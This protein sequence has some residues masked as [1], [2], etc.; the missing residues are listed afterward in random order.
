MLPI[1]DLSE[2]IG[3][4]R[5]NRG[6]Y[7]TSTHEH[8]QKGKYPGRVD[9]R[10]SRGSFVWNNAVDPL[11]SFWS[12]YLS[13]HEALILISFVERTV[14]GRGSFPKFKKKTTSLFLVFTLIFPAPKLGRS[15]GPI[16]RWLTTWGS[17]QLR[18]RETPSSHIKNEVV[19][20]LNW[21]LRA[22]QHCAPFW[23]ET[24]HFN[25][26][27]FPNLWISILPE[28][29]GWESVV[30][31]TR[32]RSQ[33]SL[34]IFFVS[35]Q[36]MELWQELVDDL[37][38]DNIQPVEEDVEFLQDTLKLNLGKARDA[39]KY[40]VRMLLL[41]G[42]PHSR[43]IKLFALDITSH[44]GAGVRPFNWPYLPVRISI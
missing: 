11:F 4:F 8:T 31:T 5:V 43:G 39:K 32:F 26:L 17:A 10:K 7:I 36:T 15:S 29:T 19:F 23:L 25:T 14:K 20:V 33:P 37:D 38:E 22:P 18:S 27:C 41:K 12:K 42:I 16:L 21:A 13:K 28:E 40:Q 44:H 24:P 9:W 1:K 35:V 30:E 6:P 2:A 34:G 3:F